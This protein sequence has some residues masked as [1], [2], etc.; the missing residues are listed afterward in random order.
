MRPADVK[1]VRVLC[2]ASR[3]LCPNV[4]GA[5]DIVAAYESS[6]ELVREIYWALR[7][8]WIKNTTLT[9]CNIANASTSQGQDRRVQCAEAFLRATAFMQ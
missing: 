5:I 4:R 8:S 2:Q 7:Q 1:L 9:P 3:Q 6:Q